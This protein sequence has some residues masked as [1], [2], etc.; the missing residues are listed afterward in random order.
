MSKSPCDAHETIIPSTSVLTRLQR[1]PAF[2]GTAPSRLPRP[3]ST[4]RLARLV[5]AP[6]PKQS[7]GQSC[8]VNT[9]DHPHRTT[10]SLYPATSRHIILVVQI[11][12]NQNFRMSLERAAIDESRQAILSGFA[13]SLRDGPA[14]RGL[15]QGNCDRR[16]A[17]AIF[18]VP[19]LPQLLC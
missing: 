9:G 18:R 6:S 3:P 7:S 1:R 10:N 4:L 13:P 11:V 19:N 17:L 16:A 12:N 2:F 8:R 5:A 14:T 15:F